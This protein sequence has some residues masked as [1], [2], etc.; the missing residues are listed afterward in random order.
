MLA[1]GNQQHL[2]LITCDPDLGDI[3][4]STQAGHGLPL[5]LDSNTLGVYLPGKLRADNRLACPA[6]FF[7]TKVI[8]HTVKSY[9]PSRDSDELTL[10]L[11]LS[12]S[13]PLLTRLDSRP[14]CVSFLLYLPLTINPRCR[15]RPQASSFNLK[16]TL[17]TF[18]GLK[19]VRLPVYQF[20][21]LKTY[22]L[23]PSAEV[24]QYI[25]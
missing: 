3:S 18:S 21:G 16:F 10:A 14:R 6:T 13:L 20:L 22:S 4:D 19:M 1:Y 17:A 9:L 11:A 15:S 23:I 5:A 2:S 8:C 24:N 7:P 25:E 12:P